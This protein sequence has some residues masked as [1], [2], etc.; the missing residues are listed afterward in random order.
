[1]LIDFQRAQV[2]PL[3]DFVSSCTFV[4]SLCREIV[5][6]IA[7]RSTAGAKSFAKVGPVALLN[8]IGVTS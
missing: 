6:R 2:A 7:E 4:I 3:G 5:W 8:D 1:M